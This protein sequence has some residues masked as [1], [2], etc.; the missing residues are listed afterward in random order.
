MV[1]FQNDIRFLLRRGGYL[2][3][4]DGPRHGRV[5]RRRYQHRPP[6]TSTRRWPRSSSSPAPGPTP[7]TGTAW[8][9]CWRP[10]GTASIA[11]DL[12]CDDDGAGFPEYA[13]AVVAAIDDAAPRRDVV[14]VAQSMA[15]FTAPIVCTRVPVEMMVMVAAMVP[16]PGESGGDWWDEHRSGRRPRR[17]DG[18]ARRPTEPYDE[19]AVFLHDVPADVVAES[20]HHLR[21][22]SGT[23]FEAPW[24]LDAWPD[25]AT[26]FLLCRD[27]RLFPADFQRRVVVARLGIMPDEMDGGHLPALAHPEELTAHLLRYAAELPTA[28]DAPVI[29]HHPACDRWRWR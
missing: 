22:Q 17:G 19:A 3:R 21:E 25:V 10:P 23:P 26:R 8:S 9:R 28:A 18:G 24:P 29:P 5:G 14:L 27:D 13:D 12:P 15:G 6:K 7:G 4:S 2:N 1:F 16:A 11:V 20:A